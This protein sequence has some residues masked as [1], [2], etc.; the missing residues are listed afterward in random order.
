MGKRLAPTEWWPLANCQ[1]PVKLTSRSKD[2]SAK[3]CLE[4]SQGV[5]ANL[6]LFLCLYK[7]LCQGQRVT[8]RGWVR[9]MGEAGWDSGGGEVAVWSPSRGGNRRLSQALA[10]SPS[11]HSTV[12]LDLTHRRQIQRWV[13]KNLRMKTTEC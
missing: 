12:P 4:M 5:Q 9:Q 1:T 7:G 8:A 6:Y 13:D 2:S 11:T 10:L 3:Y